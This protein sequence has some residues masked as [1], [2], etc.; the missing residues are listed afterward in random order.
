[1]TEAIRL[2]CNWDFRQC[3]DDGKGRTWAKVDLPHSPFVADL[4]GRDHWFGECEYRRNIEAVLSEGARA[5][6]CV[7]AAMHTCRAF[8]GDREIACHTGGYLPFEIDLTGHLDS[9]GRAQLILRLDNR[10][11]PDVP[12]GK[13]YDDLDFCWY[14]GL[15]RGVSLQIRPAVHLTSTISAGEAAGGGIFLRTLAANNESA[16]VAARIHVANTSQTPRTVRVR[17][18]F[19]SG[20]RVASTATS[21]AL[22]LGPGQARH[23]E[24]K[25][26]FSQPALWSPDHPALHDVAVTVLD[27][28]GHALDSNQLRFGIR[29]IAFSRAG[30]FVINGQR[31]RLRGTNRHQ[32]LPRVGYA[33]PRA[34]QHRDA[35][36][37]KEAGFDYVRLSHYPQAPEFLDACDELGLVVMA[38]IPGWQFLGGERFREAVFDDTRQLVRRDRNHACVVLWELSLNET[39]MDEEFMA[40][41]HAIGHEEYP[42]DQM[43]TCGW[44]DR[45][46]VFSH[47][48]QHGEIHRW[49]NG[50]KAIVISEY[51]DW[52][53][54]ARN[55]GFDQKTGAGVYDRSTTSRQFRGDGERGMLQQAANHV[56]ALN[57]TLASPAAFD[58]QWAVFDYAR[59]YSHERAA[60]GIM[61][62]FRLPKFSYYFYRSQRNPAEGGNGWMGG[63]LVFIASHWTPA[64]SLRITVFSNCEKVALHLNGRFVSLNAPLQSSFTQHL[65]H[66]PFSFD[67]SCFEPGTLEAIGYIDG[68]PI[69]SHVVATPKAFARLELS[70]DSLGINAGEGESDVLFVH[71]SLVD[72][73][74]TLCVQAT[75]TITFAVDGVSLIGPNMLVPEA[76]IASTVVRLSPGTTQFSVIASAPASSPV[77]PITCHWR[78][79]N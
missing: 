57:D 64:S 44:I 38:C 60:V 47:A 77:K 53:Y 7:G 32:E 6:L 9:A 8:I 3:T 4:D 65:A 30:G 35:R 12:P 69:A 31:R 40:R 42:G 33:V 13:P 10:D 72:A 19:S 25:F 71:A 23:V 45:Y 11:N 24:T 76:G 70:V 1:M 62:I 63:P 21:D 78:A 48:R 43:Y 67:L 61:D 36:R 37:I 5:I 22:V 51:G 50:D 68:E 14:S 27:E 41:L 26:V 17:T 29:R 56:M 28:S 2:D 34:A 18:E 39:K 49:Q 66:P 75:D 20:G 59:G 74:G 52:E 73:N 54:Y 46:D 55:E 15:Y 58:G 16:E 79:E